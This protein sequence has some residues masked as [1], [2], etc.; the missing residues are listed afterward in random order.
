MKIAITA[1]IHIN[2]N[3]PQR[4]S[5]LKNILDQI[6]KDGIKYLIIAGDTFDEKQ[7]NYSELDELVKPYTDVEIYLLPGNHDPNLTQGHFSAPNIKVISSPQIITFDNLEVFFI[8]YKPGK[9]MDEIIV[10]N[11]PPLEGNWIIVSHGDYIST[12]H[13]L[14][15]YEEGIYMP[16][17]AYTVEKLNPLKVFLGHIHKHYSAGKVHYPGSPFPVDITETGKRKYLIFDTETYEVT[18]K[19]VDTECIYFDE[20]L[21]I[22]PLEN[23]HEIIELQLSRIIES[24]KLSQHELPKVRLRLK[25]KG[26]SKD[27][28]ELIKVVRNF[29]TQKGIKLFDDIDDSEVS[30]PERESYGEKI[31]IFKLTQ[32]ELAKLDESLLQGIEIREVEEQILRII[33]EE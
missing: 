32:E 30:V 17:S 33:F 3:Y 20:V 27:K 4:L 16:L 10:E 25:L 26:F 19:D 5:A 2:K 21:N 18:S 13:T 15:P 31:E 22:Y 7:L 29:L 24:W 8:P 12:K 28:R 6:T 23:E 11:K 9:T 1:D 14:N